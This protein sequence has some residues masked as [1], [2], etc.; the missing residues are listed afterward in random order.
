MVNPMPTTDHGDT[1]P[2]VGLRVRYHG[3]HARRTRRPDGTPEWPPAPARL[4]AALRSTLGDAV[5]PDLHNAFAALCNSPA[6]VIIAELDVGDVAPTSRAGALR[7]PPEKDPVGKIPAL[8]KPGANGQ[9]K[10][11]DSGGFRLGTVFVGP[12][13]SVINENR[14]VDPHSHEVLYLIDGL[15]PS[16]AHLIDRLA[17]QV[18]YLGGSDDLAVLDVI[19]DPDLLNKTTENYRNQGLVTL[20]PVKSRRRTPGAVTLRGW[21][22]DYPDALDHRWTLDDRN[23]G[24]KGV[25]H[26][27][28]HPDQATPEVHYRPVLRSRDNSVTVVK[29]DRPVKNNRRLCDRIAA[30][31]DNS[32]DTDRIWVAPV[33]SPYNATTTGLVIGTGDTTAATAASPV[34]T[35]IITVAEDICGGPVTPGPPGW[36]HRYTGSSRYWTSVTPVQAPDARIAWWII[37]TGIAELTGLDPDSIT[38][39]TPSPAD[40]VHGGVSTIPG[41]RRWVT[42]LVTLPEPAAGPFIVDSGRAVFRTID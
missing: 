26:L 36:A 30:I 41:M 11:L 28:P 10:K 37:R 1:T 2:P 42:P 7:N 16:Q 8:P 24:G 5:D 9:F 14:A 27:P 21:S 38:V 34:L 13:G 39:E 15:T 18:P 12:N 29:L 32:G 33:I 20:V 25:L 31:I 17:E 6:P 23:T 40:A 35:A 4:A 3:A 22:P 19:T